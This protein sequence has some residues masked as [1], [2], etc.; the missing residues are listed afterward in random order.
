M[1]KISIRSMLVAPPGKLLVSV[2][3][4]QAESWIVAYLADEPN[5]Q[6]SLNYSDIH[7]DSAAALFFENNYCIHE[8]KD[9]AEGAKCCKKCELII[10]KTARYIGKRYNHAS[11]Y[12]MK[13]PRAAQV[14]N[15]DS[16]K[17]PFVVITL[18]ESRMYSERWHRRYNIKLWWSEIEQ[19]LSSNRTL[20]TTYGRRRTFFGQW[21]EEL[22]KEATAF[23]PQSTVADHFNGV[24]HPELRIEGGLQQIYIQL[25]KPYPDRMIIKVS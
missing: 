10:V 7:S 15:K 19:K 14:I 3:L 22:F 6:H 12:R 1:K 18:E 17:P 8:W 9:I 25:I 24:T 4:S 21:G 20:T 11:A 13:P 16:D 5:M 2:D 23:E